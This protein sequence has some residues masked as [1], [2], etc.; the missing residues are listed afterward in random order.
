MLSQTLSR[1]LVAATALLL[2]V[3]ATPAEAAVSAPAPGLRVAQGSLAEHAAWTCGPQK[4]V[5]V[6]GY[7]GGVPA[8]ARGWA[9]PRYAD[10]YWKRRLSGKWKYRCHA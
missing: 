9:P 4:C 10:C 1:S 2:A 3:D 8:F 6:P 7:L 5:W